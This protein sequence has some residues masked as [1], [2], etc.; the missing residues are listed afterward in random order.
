MITEIKQIKEDPDTNYGYIK[1]TFALKAIGYYVNKKKVYR[2]MKQHSMLASKNIMTAKNYAKYRKVLPEKPLE[3]LEMDIKFVWVEQYKRHALII[4][5]IDTFTRHILHYKVAYSIKKEQVKEC[6]DH[7]IANHLQAYLQP[8][9]SINIE[10]RNDNDKRFSAKL[11]Q[12]YF[13]ENYINQVFTHPYTPQENGHVESFHAILSHHLEPYNF[14][15]IQELEQ[16]L[17]LFYEKYNNTRIHSSI[18]YLSPSN[19]WQLWDINLIEKKT[20]YKLRK[21]KFKLKIP[22]DQINLH[23]GNTEPEVVPLHIVSHRNGAP[24]SNS[25]E[26]VSAES[27]HN[28][29]SKTSPSV[30]PCDTNI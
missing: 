15:S 29:R 21:T 14:W 16:N 10:I 13:A 3:V 8:N 24:I 7:V 9:E 2:L 19:F 27:S 5:I 1:M 26:M 30:V 23:T 6:W 11:I 25:K 4:T 12:N 28:I 18:A 20:D 17:I 22:Y